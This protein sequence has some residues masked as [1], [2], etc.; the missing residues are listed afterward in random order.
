MLV[1]VTLNVD[2]LDNDI[3]NYINLNQSWKKRLVKQINLV[4]QHE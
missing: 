4:T 3:L 1:R 2:L